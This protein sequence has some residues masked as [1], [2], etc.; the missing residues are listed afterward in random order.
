MNR[1][2]SGYLKPTECTSSAVMPGEEKGHKQRNKR[3]E[4]K[5]NIGV[6]LYFKH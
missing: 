5:K 1:I 4:S 2:N 6:Y 3:D